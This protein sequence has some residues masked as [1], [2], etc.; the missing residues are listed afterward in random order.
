MTT[1]RYQT[2]IEA[3]VI[4]P[5]HNYVGH[6]GGPAGMEPAVRREEVRLLPGR[7]IEGDRYSLREGNHPKQITFFDADT[8]EALARH[9]GHEV[10]PEAVRRNVFTRGVDLNLL[11]GKVFSIQ[12]VRFEGTQHCHPCFWMNEAVGPGAEDF[13]KNRG[14]LRARILDEGTLRVG[15]APLAINLE[16][17]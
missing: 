11:V 8:L 3:I 6:F 9:V 10:H 5:A 17:A 15:P 1:P 4:S 14:G 2:V 16:N 7:G 12:G 13:L